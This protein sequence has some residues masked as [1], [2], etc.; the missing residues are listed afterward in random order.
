MSGYANDE[1]KANYYGHIVTGGNRDL[2]DEK[3]EE[4]Q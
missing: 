3:A 2:Y 1:R 4:L